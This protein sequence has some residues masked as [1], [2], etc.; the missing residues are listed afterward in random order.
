MSIEQPT[1]LIVEDDL[2]IRELLS[3]LLQEGYQVITTSNGEEALERI[4][5]LEPDEL[6]LILLDVMMPQMDGFE[7]LHRLRDNFRTE[8]IP[9]VFLTA[10]NEDEQ[11][12]RG[13]KLGAIDYIVKPFDAEVLL[14][15]VHNHIQQK[16]HQD[17]LHQ[18]SM[19][20]VVTNLYNRRQFDIRLGEEWNRCMR[21][22]RELALLMIDIDYFKRYNDAYGHTVGDN[23][24]AKV[25]NGIQSV[26]MRSSDFVARYGGEEFVV[27][28]PETNLEQAIQLAN[29]A[30]KKMDELDIPNVGS[31]ISP[32]ITVSIGIAA[33]LPETKTSEIELVVAADKRLYQAKERG[34]GC[35]M[36]TRH[37][38]TI[39][40]RDNFSVGHPVMDDHHKRLV[41]YINELIKFIGQKDG[42][43]QPDV[44]ALI[45]KINSFA[46]MHFEA[47]ESL[48]SSL[49]Y[50]SLPSQLSA[51]RQYR[52]L[53]SPFFSEA[54][55]S[56]IVEELVTLLRDWWENHI[57]VD[58]MVYKEYLIK[59]DQQLN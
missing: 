40:W 32:H 38:S 1:V 10:L 55:N 22:E 34:R 43:A 18:M 29:Q 6:D 30:L 48:L 15:K 59:V 33:T 41:G 54:R 14:L 3:A 49:D 35:V 16:H 20:D 2:E 17:R 26:F 4:D 52:E 31:K 27:L 36:P 12:K 9:V 25:A 11:R 21:N 58:D 13:L 57:L 51:H 7:L 28:L 46:D 37:L 45:T 42:E 44:M 50:P 53:L 5:N 39:Q 8:T 23:C 24:L 56:I 19:I 47:E